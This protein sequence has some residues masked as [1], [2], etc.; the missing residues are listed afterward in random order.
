MKPLI[1][2]SSYLLRCCAAV[3]RGAFVWQHKNKRRTTM[4]IEDSHAHYQ[5]K[6]KFLEQKSCELCGK[7]SL[8]FRLLLRE[9][10]LIHSRFYILMSNMVK[11]SFDLLHSQRYPAHL[12]CLL[13][14]WHTAWPHSL[15]W[16]S[17]EGFAYS[18]YSLLWS[19]S[20][21]CVLSNEEGYST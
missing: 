20:A 17:E 4:R 21:Y 8:F 13:C 12:H 10:S 3:I 7:H 11:S 16:S 14:R 18:G 5:Q 19:L 9:A 15:P 6:Q 2:F 1:S